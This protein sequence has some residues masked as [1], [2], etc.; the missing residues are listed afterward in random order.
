MVDVFNLALP[1]FGLIFIGYVCGRA[2]AFPEAG[3]AWMNLFLL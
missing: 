3:W 2:K 1:H